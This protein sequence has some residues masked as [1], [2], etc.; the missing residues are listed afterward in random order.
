MHKRLGLAVCLTAIGSALGISGPADVPDRA[1]AEATRFAELATG[2]EKV[3]SFDIYLGEQELNLIVSGKKAKGQAEELRFF[4]SGDGGAT[5]GKPVPIATAGE[6]PY[7]PTPGNAVQLARQG[8]LAVALW[9]TTGTG[10]KGT[11]TGAYG[12]LRA[13]RS[14]DGGQTWSLP[15]AVVPRAANDQSLDDVIIDRSGH[16]HAVWVDSVLANDEDAAALAYAR[17]EDQGRT[18]STPRTVD[19]SICSCCGTRLVE[20]GDGA[21]SVLYR[22]QRPRDMLVS[23]TRDAGARWQSR[24]HAGAFGWQFDGCP[25]TVSGFARDGA[26][27][28]ATVWTGMPGRQGLYAVKTTDD[29]QSWHRPVKLTDGIAKASDLSVVNQTVVSAVW[30]EVLDDGVM[31]IAYS[32]SEDR[33][34]TWRTPTILQQSRTALLSSPR[35]ATTPRGQ[36]IFWIEENGSTARLLTAF[37]AF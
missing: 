8:D 11:S 15:V 29:G 31:A 20:H 21:L 6:P 2:L 37:V 34:E 30:S 35:I 32:R 33:A 18:W 36:M 17:S 13:A 9:W 27:L 4:S 16:I 10:W 5:W 28:F 3:T 7:S 14:L 26:V 1:F 25:E 23:E 19:N 22:D 24:G 12:P